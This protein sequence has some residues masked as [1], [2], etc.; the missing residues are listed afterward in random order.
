MNTGLMSKPGTGAF[1]PA[2][3][4]CL[5]AA[6]TLAGDSSPD[7]A[8]IAQIEADWARQEQRLGRTVG[9]PPAVAAAL[10]RGFALLD[11]LASRFPAPHPAAARPLSNRELASDAP[12]TPPGNPPA[13]A[14]PTWA[15]IRTT[16]ESLQREA[17]AA[18]TPE[19]QLQL[20]RR[21]RWAVRNMALCAPDVA[22]KP[23]VFLSRRRFVCQ[24]L[25]EYLGYYYDY[26]D[27]AGGG[28]RVLEQP[29]RSF[30]TR[31]LIANRL[32]RGN[33]STLAL[34]F[35]ART[36]Y[37]AF[38]ERAPAKPD[39]YSPNRRCFHVF[40]VATDGSDL[41]R[42]TDGPDDDFDPCPLP[43]GGIAFMSSRRGGFGR[44]HN[45]WEPLPSCTLHRM[46][47]DGT[48]IQTLSWHE[49][50]EW[51]PWVLNDGRIVYTRWDYVDRS[52]ANYHG[53]W[54]SNPDG[55]NPVS[56]FGNYTT[57]IN[58]C[59]QP[60]AIPNSQCIVFVAGAHHAD[61]GGSLVLLDPRKIALDPGT[62][63]DDLR[64]IERLTPE[65]CFAEADGW[66]KSYFHAPWP[67][68]EQRYLVGFSFDPLPGMS[69]GE[70]RDTQTGLYYFDRW[71]NL[72][73]LYRDP[74]ASAMYPVPLTPRPVPP[75]LPSA[76]DRGLGEE[77]EFLVQN[78]RQ[79]LMP[80]PADRPARTLRV[81]QVL[82]KTPPH[83]ANQPRLGH[84]NAESARA[85][86]GSVPV[87]AD[88]SVQFR[89]PARKPLYFQLVDEAGR[90]IQTMRSITYLQPGERRGCVGCHEPRA[91]TAATAR[92]PLASLYPPARLEPG[93]EGSLPFSYPLLVQPVLDRACVRC[94]DGTSGPGK[95]A[96]DLTG[97]S[98]GTFSRSYLNLKPFLRWHEWGG[99]SISQ[100]ATRPTHNGADESP[101]RAVLDN[102][103]HAPT[104]LPDADR[105][106]LYLWLDA[107]VPFYGTYSA[108]EQ[109]AQ[110]RGQTVPLP[111]VQ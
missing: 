94:H 108:P 3:V 90:A 4:S 50:N 80:L 30:K 84:A 33:Y 100:T 11:H 34:S 29:G 111:A 83:I 104:G 81:Y 57:R 93:P 82:P 66:P 21:V 18:V 74:E 101:L 6:L 10:D 54:I 71:G 24:M 60:R 78:V 13:D 88:G 5:V 27:V 2:L 63:E 87:Q 58:A 107:N 23:L 68:S 36:A 96:L 77:G 7:P 1:G 76:L 14:A 85:L 52:A 48:A 38:A 26:G 41:R 98:A 42:L 19:A 67:L 64:A 59:Y 97:E 91:T 35:D 102:P 31:D 49:T 47:A 55:S 92:P 32:P 25:H 53:L 106:R 16:L 103:T 95:S 9:S 17:A 79:S 105:R 110:R 70:S 46:D 75:R 45:V 65:V 56:L 62:G 40:A 61:V 44:C 109:L 72:E 20:Y 8:F 99:N 22:D 43:D 69:S 73:L 86:L 51:H 37:F 39:F 12:D 89:A 15:D 28:V